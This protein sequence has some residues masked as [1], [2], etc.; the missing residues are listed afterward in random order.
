V[1]VWLRRNVLV[2]SEQ[3]D[4]K[5]PVKTNPRPRSQHNLHQEQQRLRRNA[6]QRRRNVD[7]GITRRRPERYSFPVLQLT[8]GKK[9]WLRPGHEYTFGRNP[10]ISYTSSHLT[11]DSRIDL[12]AYKTVSKLHL[13][14]KVGQVTPGSAVCLLF[15]N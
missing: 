12:S 7:S 14:I 4:I 1:S 3:E 2:A 5:G 8:E 11:A 13:T 9:Y 10:S 15:L 6:T